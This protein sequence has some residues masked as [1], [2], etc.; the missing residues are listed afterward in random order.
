MKYTCP[1]MNPETGERR[2]VVV[3]LD[4]WEL[5]DVQHNFRTASLITRG[6]VMRRASRLVP[7]FDPVVNSIKQVQV[8]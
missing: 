4:D 7:G 5:D 8:H 1:V 6:Y 2:V 3:E